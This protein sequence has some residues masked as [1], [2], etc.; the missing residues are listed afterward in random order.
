MKTRYSAYLVAFFMVFSLLSLGTEGKANE[1]SSGQVKKMSTFLSN[2]TELGFYSF[3]AKDILNEKNPGDMIRFGIWHNYI[4]NFKSRIRN[5]GNQLSIDGKFVKESVKKY[6]N[7]NM[8]RLVSSGR[9]KFDGKKYIFDGADGEAIY[10]A[11]VTS[12]K[13]IAQGVIEMKGYLYNIEDKSDRNGTFV[14]LAKPYKYNGKNTWS[15]VSMR[16]FN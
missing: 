15:I 10:Y 6:F 1:F 12:A 13:S 8:K 2:F 5:H 3:T 16:H 11:Q 14:A 7:Y 4:N 9:F